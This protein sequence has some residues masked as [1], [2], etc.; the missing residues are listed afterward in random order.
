M[1]SEGSM[2]SIPFT[3]L[4][5]LMLFT[6]GAGAAQAV[7]AGAAPK[8]LVAVFAH[9]DDEGAAAPILARYARE[10]VQV[11]LVIAT[12]GAQGGKYTSIP[13][14]PELA[15]ARAEEARCA[16]DALG[17]RPP[18]LLG[19]PD[20]K[21]GD[22]VGD[23]SLLY[24]LT[25]RV[26]AELERLRPDARISYGP[27]GAVGHPDHRLVSDIVTQLV[28]AGAPGVPERLFYATIPVEG[29]RAMNP[30]R[31]AP[32]M[33]VPLAKYL[34]VRVP[35]TSADLE[36]AHRSMACHRTQYTE[37]VVQRVFPGMGAAWNGAVRLAPALSTVPGTD[38]FR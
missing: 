24:R 8:T 6:P 27:D 11:Y 5:G 3:A 36:A 17:I 30:Q 16:T 15:R 20:G 19:F 31:G 37:E 38:L 18:I 12:D 35:F 29:I 10:G 14:G 23:P 28:R 21:L 32:P 26:Q 22:Y 2:R 33:L 7:A 13:R 9:G 1:S 34:S 4:V 25:Q